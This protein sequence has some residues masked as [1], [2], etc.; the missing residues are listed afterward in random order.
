MNTIAAAAVTPIII[1]MASSFFL[2]PVKSAIAPSIGD[3]SA[4]TATE[5][6][7]IA[8]KRAVACAGSRSA[9]AYVV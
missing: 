9:A 5:T 8:P 6:V 1:E 4:M 2:M 3:A 7:V